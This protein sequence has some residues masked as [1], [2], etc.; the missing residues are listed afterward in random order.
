[1]A[2]FRYLIFFPLIF[3]LS[4]SYGNYFIPKQNKTYGETTPAAIAIS[5]VDKLNLNY[6]DLARVAVTV[7]GNADEAREALQEEASRIGA[8]AIIQFRVQRTYFRTS[9]SGLAIRIFTRN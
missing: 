2:N 9:A 1:M 6:E 3:S 8:N 4:C 7:L 5:P